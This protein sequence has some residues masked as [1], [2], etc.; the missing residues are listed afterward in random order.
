MQSPLPVRASRRVR[1][2][3]AASGTLPQTR[4]L[5]SHHDQR[6]DLADPHQPRIGNLRACCNVVSSRCISLV[7]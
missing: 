7:T 3:R 6:P 2:W 5:V 4:Q 1:R